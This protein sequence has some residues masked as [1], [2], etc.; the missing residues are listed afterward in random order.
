MSAASRVPLAFSVGG[1]AGGVLAFGTDGAGAIGRA[2][3]RVTGTKPAWLAGGSGRAEGRP[4]RFELRATGLAGIFRS[5]SARG[6]GLG[7]G[8]VD[9]AKVDVGGD[10]CSGGAGVG[11]FGSSGEAGRQT[12]SVQIQSGCE[13]AG[14]VTSSPSGTRWALATISQTTG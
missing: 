13:G 9:A 6:A 11:G 4:A 2:V 14:A 3:G 5:G 8:A 1:L 7:G 12:P 10:G